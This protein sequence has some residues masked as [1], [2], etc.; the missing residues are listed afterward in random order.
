MS[1]DDQRS[2]EKPGIRWSVGAIGYLLLAFVVS[3]F[4]VGVVQTVL[5]PALPVGL[6]ESS[7][8]QVAYGMAGFLIS[9][10]IA[11]VSVKQKYGGLSQVEAQIPK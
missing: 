10:G 6:E 5:L 3:A 4:L 1:P 9:A 2:P 8:F 7:I 11:W